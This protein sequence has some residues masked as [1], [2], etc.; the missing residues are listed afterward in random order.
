M[1]TTDYTGFTTLATSVADHIATVTMSGTGPG[2]A[3]G[4]TFFTEL[5]A[6]FA[7]LAADDD[8]RVV[9]LRGSGENFSFG[10][11]LADMAPVLDRMAPGAS[12]VDRRE[13]LV[14]LRELQAAL[15]AVAQCPK[16][17]VAAIDGWCIGGG[18]DLIAAADIRVA[19]ASARFSIREARMGMVADLGSLQRLGA[20]IGDGN[21]RELALTG[22][23][24]EADIARDIGLVTRLC[25]DG[26]ELVRIARQV[27]AEIAANSP[28]VT[29]GIKDVLE[30]DRADRVE[31]GLRYVGA[32]NAAFLAS[33]DLAEARG[34]FAA[35]RPPRFEGR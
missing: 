12:A 25:A 26:E 15:T 3:M 8:A 22:R 16:P 7:A 20:I 19:T 14:R 2:N 9:V 34:A 27:A 28:L 1:T 31:A 13:F 29:A 5:P 4:R 33:E 18:V 17:V 23:D 35:K 30:A 24:F 11:D 21:L 6:L 10:L 32:W